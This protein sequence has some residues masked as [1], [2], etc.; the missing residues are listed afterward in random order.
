MDAIVLKRE[1]SA[2]IESISDIEVLQ[3]LKTL[4]SHKVSKQ[5]D[6]WNTISEE[7]RIEIKQ[8]LEEALNEEVIPHDEILKKY[9]KWLV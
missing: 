3:A 2:L 1:I 7:E 8:G 4:L 6:W 5:A 9:M